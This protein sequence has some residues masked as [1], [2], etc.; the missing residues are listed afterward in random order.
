MQGGV[1]QKETRAFAPMCPG[2]ES[3]ALRANPG[4]GEMTSQQRLGVDPSGQGYRWSQFSPE[5]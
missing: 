3:E 5:W 2:S 1:Q 4:G